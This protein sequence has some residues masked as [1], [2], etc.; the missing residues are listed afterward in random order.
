MK[1]P[2][3]HRNSSARQASTSPA[4]LQEQMRRR[5]FELWELSGQEHG[6]DTEHWLQAEQE[7]IQPTKTT[8]S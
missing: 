4:D 7:V 8:E 6:H 5:A 1:K 2:A 3:K